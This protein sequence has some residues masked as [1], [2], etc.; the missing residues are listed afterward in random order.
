MK[1]GL[2]NL[3]SDRCENIVG[4]F[5]N[6]R[7]CMS[8]RGFNLLC[9]NERMERITDPVNDIEGLEYVILYYDSN[10]RHY[11][12]VVSNSKRQRVPTVPYRQVI[13]GRLV[14]TNMKLQMSFRNYEQVF[15]TLWLARWLIIPYLIVQAW[16]LSWFSSG[17]SFFCEVEVEFGASK[18]VEEDDQRPLD[19][20]SYERQYND[21]LR[22]C[23]LVSRGSGFGLGDRNRVVGYVSMARFIPFKEEFDRLINVRQDINNARVMMNKLAREIN[24]SGSAGVL[25]A[26]E[27]MELFIACANNVIVNKER[28]EAIFEPKLRD[29]SFKTVAAQAFRDEDTMIGKGIKTG[30]AANKNSIVYLQ[31]PQE[32]TRNVVARAPIGSLSSFGETLGGGLY[33]QTN[34]AMQAAS[35]VGRSCSSIVQ[36]ETGE[37]RE[38]INF[39]RDFI[40]KIVDDTDFSGVGHIN[41]D[42]DHEAIFR[43]HALHKFSREQVDRLVADHKRAVRNPRASKKHFSHSFFVKNENSY[44][45][46][47]GKVLVR[48]RGIMTMSAYHYY[49]LSPLL[50]VFEAFYSGPIKR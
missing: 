42:D 33:P 40:G 8:R 44:M 36:V 6:L 3:S 13:G 17:P 38:F 14:E 12:L 23:R 16:I 7:E 11:E 48:P 10:A 47:D 25:E 37:M 26:R 27:L 9:V 29:V 2:R 5:E 46:R 32:K 24:A 18:V 1:R 41:S 34:P 22:C 50:D 39:A 4:S 15:G 35:F 45:V 31:V 21:V 20:R 19:I 30:K 28:P 49:M 43:R